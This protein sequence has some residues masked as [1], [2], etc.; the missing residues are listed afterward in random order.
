MASD[1]ASGLVFAAHKA[2]SVSTWSLGANSKCGAR[3][4]Q[5]GG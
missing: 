4:S 5:L 1:I 2:N 3:S